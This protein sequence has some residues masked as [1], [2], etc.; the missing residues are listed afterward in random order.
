[1]VLNIFILHNA[2]SRIFTYVNMRVR[3]IFHQIFSYYIIFHQSHGHL[4]NHPCF[5]KQEKNYIKMEIR[6]AAFLVIAI[7]ITVLTNKYITKNSLLWWKFLM[8][9]RYQRA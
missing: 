3:Y 6:S 2:E 8:M 5:L 7:A 1:M 9:L 4:K